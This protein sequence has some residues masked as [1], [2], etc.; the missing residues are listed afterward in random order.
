MNAVQREKAFLK[1]CFFNRFG[2]SLTDSTFAGLPNVAQ[3]FTYLG[4][5]GIGPVLPLEVILIW[6]VAKSYNSWIL[7]FLNKQKIKRSLK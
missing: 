7:K 1:I 3:L 6:W 2:S 4:G 5:G